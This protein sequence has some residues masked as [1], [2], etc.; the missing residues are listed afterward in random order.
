MSLATAKNSAIH[1]IRSRRV[2][3]IA[4]GATV[5]SLGSGIV[6]ARPIAQMEVSLA[7]LD[8]SRPEDAQ[9][10]YAKLN[11]AAKQV[12]IKVDLMEPRGLKSRNQCY[13]IALANAVNSV[14]NAYLTQLHRS[15]KRVWLAQS[16]LDRSN[17]S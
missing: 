4:L 6:Q 11:K 14:N 16:V 3:M 5:L 13:R 15:D 8:L 10:A 7:G 12:C 1:A 9:Q 17:A 2:A